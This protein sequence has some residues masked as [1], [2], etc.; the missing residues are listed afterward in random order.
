[1]QAAWHQVGPGKDVRSH[2]SPLGPWTTAARGRGA[3]VGVSKWG[4]LKA[5]VWGRRAHGVLHAPGGGTVPSRPGDLLPPSKSPSRPQAL[6]GV[7]VSGLT[8]RVRN[9][10][11]GR[12]PAVSA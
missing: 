5:G 2:A 7:R 1:M 8:R 6:L 11:Y 9:Q 12:T 10:Q 3:Q 4:L